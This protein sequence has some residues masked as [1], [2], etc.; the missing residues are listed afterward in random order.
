MKMQLHLLAKKIGQNWLDFGIFSWIWSKFCISKNIRFPTAMCK[1]AMSRGYQVGMA[2]LLRL[3]KFLKSRHPSE[4][5]DVRLFDMTQKLNFAKTLATRSYSR[6]RR[7]LLIYLSRYLDQETTK[8]PF[9]SSSQA[10]TCYYLFN[11]DTFR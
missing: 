2:W 10:A 11:Q 1:R 8:W 6:T 5:F 7:Y 3:V 9:R 4:V